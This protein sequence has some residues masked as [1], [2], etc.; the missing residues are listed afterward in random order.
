MAECTKLGISDA[1][2]RLR[3]VYEYQGNNGSEGAYAN[4]AVTT[5]TYS[6]LDLL[7]GVSDANSNATSLGYDHWAAKRV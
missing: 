3:W 7:T 6:P 5:Y 2:G 1:L 4:P